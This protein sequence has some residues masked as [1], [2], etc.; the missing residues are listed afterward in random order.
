MIR[1]N[2]LSKD[3]SLREFDLDAVVDIIDGWSQRRVGWQGFIVYLPEQQVFVELLSTVPDV[4]G[5]SDSQREEVD[6]DYLISAYSLTAQQ[7][8]DIQRSPRT[9][10]FVR[11][12]K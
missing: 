2:F 1:S 3:G 11:G 9:W 8:L 12:R 4:R 10:Q 6:R 7:L 5:N